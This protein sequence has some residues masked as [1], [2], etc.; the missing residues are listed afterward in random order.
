M[1]AGSVVLFDKNPGIGGALGILVDDNLIDGVGV[2]MGGRSLNKRKMSVRSID[3]ERMRRVS[4]SIRRRRSFKDLTSNGKLTDWISL[5]CS[6]Y[7][8]LL[9]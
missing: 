4:V 6:F 9:W 7:D 8:R 3:K 5:A 2:G 1:T